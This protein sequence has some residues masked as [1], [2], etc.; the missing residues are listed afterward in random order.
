ME[1]LGADW[2]FQ[3]FVTDQSRV[4]FESDPVVNASI[5]TGRVNLTVVPWFGREEYMRW[6]LSIPFWESVR[7]DWV[8]IFHSDSIICRNSTLKPEDFFAWDYCGAPWWNIPVGGNSGFSVTPFPCFSPFL[9]SHQFVQLRNKNAMIRMLRMK[10]RE[11]EQY[12]KWRGG[13]E[14]DVFIGRYGL[15]LA[16]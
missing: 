5:L 10:R 2:K 11:V 12:L 4:P 3:L 13:Q 15:Q 9:P 7:G 6:Q 1:V 8:I 14:E 16:C